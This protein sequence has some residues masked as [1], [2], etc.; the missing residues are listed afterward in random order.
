MTFLRIL[1]ARARALF[2]RDAIVDEI[3]EEMD[4]HLDMRA[5][6]YTRGGLDERQARREAA[7]RFG[8]VTLLRDR[9]YD[10]RGGGFMESIWQDI[11]YGARSLRQSP[12]FTAV[13]LTV[14]ALAIGAGTA[15]FSVVDAAL[16]RGLPYDEH[17]RIAAVLGV[18]TR[19]EITFGN[20]A[21]TTQTYLD[22]RRLQDSFD[23]VAMVGNT[24]LQLKNDS[25]E[26]STVAVRRV[27]WEFFPIL[28]IQP[29]AGR[30]F[31]ADDEVPGRDQ[32][33][34]LSYGFWQR[35]FGGAPDV[36]GK[37]MQISNQTWQIVGITPQ[38]FAYPPAADRP[39][40][41]YV[42]QAFR[43][44]DRVRAGSH[45]YN[46]I[47]I[48]RLKPGVSLSRADQQMNQ[49]AASVDA[50]NPAWEPGWRARVVPLHERLVGKNRQWLLLLLGAVGFVLLIA[51]ANVANLMLTRASVR[52]HEIGIRSALGAGQGR[53][54]RALLIESLLLSVA[55][56][57]IG[58]ALA[59]GGVQVL[60]AWLPAGVPRVAE[61][62]VEL[63]VLGAAL[64]T[65]IA[66]GLMFG[67]AAAVHASRPSVSWALKDS[68]RSVTPHAGRWL[69]NAL[70]IGEVSVAVVLLVGAGLFV[71]SFVQVV[72][73]EPGFDYRNT[74]VLGTF[75]RRDPAVDP[76]AEEWMKR[77]N[78]HV[79]K[80]IDAV[81]RVP[82]VLSV[83]ATTGGSP[84]SG[85][86][87]RTRVTLPGKAEMKDDADSIDYRRVTSEYFSLLRLPLLR[88]RHFTDDDRAGAQRVAIVNQAAASKYWPGRDP[89]GEHISLQGWDRL[90]VGIVADVRQGGPEQ[91][92]R[93]SV[94]VPFA[95]E[96][97]TG[98]ELLIRTSGDPM[99]LVSAIKTAAWNVNHSQGLSPEI[100][101][102]EQSMDR[103]IAPRR[104]NMAMLGLLGALGLVIAAV[105]IFGV[106][107]YT[108]TQRTS[109]IG[110]RMAL[111]ATPAG[112]VSMVL[113]GAATLI[114]AG[115]VLGAAA[116]WPLASF[117]EAFLF[118]LTPTDPR[119]FV[120]AIALLAVV[121]LFAAVIPARRAAKVD[122]LK[123][124]RET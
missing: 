56:G 45:N 77:G 91:T 95:Q 98:A 50:Q 31:N 16:L 66:T 4:F 30:L 15:I 86:Y 103:L 43:E 44:Q 115:L 38:G 79:P 5:Q 35:R 29:I 63:R 25:G 39:E 70:V 73:I 6:D 17:D 42:P 82:G 23:G 81:K 80:V 3:R 33:V 118:Q 112:I 26:P 102:L 46:S 107:A 8:N 7:H 85:G 109:E 9:G 123:S 37:T 52:S 119:V 49:V 67:M 20:G 14:L 22:W 24:A 116:A 11:R 74:L 76:N 32:V 101:T 36:I 97:A 122:P 1:L 21:T 68:G 48:G 104:F 41:L 64:A 94:F 53:I 120:G 47:V 106:M 105:G 34:I 71:T 92:P 114:A 13:A 19:S 69:R 84:L 59:Y 62:G 57:A 90:V 96:P 108:V 58:V 89:I 121:G 61:I 54:A 83:A 27:T 75:L 65:S 72:R 51:C 110:V 28:R 78:A 113:K 124:L 12:T 18:D 100:S 60:K 2:R 93:Q 88:G 111:G 117:A 10:I 99:A 40:D 55:A 87:S